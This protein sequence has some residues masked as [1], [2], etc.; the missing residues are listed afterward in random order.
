MTKREAK[1]LAKA[2]FRS[3]FNKEQFF[4]FISNLFKDYEPLAANVVGGGQLKEAFKPF[5]S[6]YER[7]GKYTD[8]ED[9]VI[10]TIIVHLQKG[11]SLERARTAQR[12][13]V[14]AYLKTREKDAALVAFVSPDSSDWRL[15]LVKFETTFQ[16]DEEKGKLKMV[17]ETT[18]AKR[19]SFLIGKNEG[20]HTVTSR[21]LDLLQ[22]DDS[23]N[24]AE[25]EA[26]FDVETVSKEFYEKYKELFLR[27]KEELDELVKK[28]ANIRADFEEKD[29]STV[30]FAKK[31]MGQMVFLYFLQK[32]GWFGVKPKET[33]G[34]G[35]KDFLRDLFNRR[36]D[37]NFFDDIMEPLFYEALASDRRDSK[38]FYSKLN[39]R[40]P[41][42][43]GGLFEPIQGYAWKS[44]H[45]RLPDK[46]FSNQ[47]KTKEGDVGDGILDIFDRY[48]FTVNES[49]PLEKEVAVD[50]EML[51][52]VFENL[53]EIKDRKSKGTYYTPREIVHYM[54]QQCLINHLETEL[55]EHSEIAREDIERL[56]L[57][58]SRIIEHEQ[59]VSKKE[60]ET[61]T[62]S[63]EMPKSIRS[64]ANRVDGLLASIKVCDPAVGSG[65]F[66]L[67]ML[68]EIIRARAALAVHKQEEIDYYE[69][70][71]HTIINSLYGVDLDGGA[72]EIAKLRLWLA[73]VVEEDEPQP[74]PNLECKIM[75][76]NSL[77]SQYEGITLFDE[78]ILF[79]DED[80]KSRETEKAE[81]TQSIATL[82]SR[83]FEVHGS[84][85]E[86]AVKQE[87]LKKIEKSIEEQQKRQK[88]LSD[89]SS[90]SPSEMS[91]FASPQERKRVHEKS[92]ELQ[93]LIKKFIVTSH[94]KKSLKEKI[95]NL[96]W[97]LIEATLKARSNEATKQRSNEA[98]KQ[99]SNEATKQRSNEATKQRSNEATK[100]LNEIKALRKKQEQPFFIWQ[101]EFLDV[102]R[103]NSGFDVVIGNPPY[104]QLQTK[105]KISA[106]IQKAYQDEN[107]HTF[108]KT[109]DIYA[110]F[111]E[112]GLNLSKP[113]TGLL[114]LI[115][116][117]KWMRA[118]YGASL[119]QFLSWHQ[120]VEC[121]DFGGYQVFDNATVDTN[122]LTIQHRSSSGQGFSACKIGEDYSRNASLRQYIQSN[123]GKLTPA[124]DEGWCLGSAAEMALKAKIEQLG[125]PLKDWD[126]NINRGILTGFNEAFIIDKEKRDELVAADPKSAEII[127][128]IL[129]GRDVQRY[130]SPWKGKYLIATLPALNLDINDYPAIKRYLQSFGRKLHQTGEVI[131]SS[132]KGTP[133]KSR[134][135][136]SNKWFETQDQIAY[137][138][139]FEKEKLAWM[140]ITNRSRCSLI[141]S[142]MYCEATAFIMTCEQPKAMTA[143]LNSSLINWYFDKICPGLGN[144]AHRW[145]KVYV[146]K[147]PMID[148]QDA[149]VQRLTSKVDAILSQANHEN[150]DPANPPKQQLNL[151]AEIDDLVFDL[152]QLTH[153]E[154][155]LIRRSVQI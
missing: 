137:Y 104:V 36:S 140:E 103:E 30:D 113:E 67:G 88:A 64:E 34:S 73:L 90:L 107:Y 144:T 129:R 154:R 97:E 72:V 71:K 105:E 1:E 153:E 26:A 19:W 139:D 15:S 149:S 114:S 99:R 61:K 86:P 16:H 134:K 29:I 25:L 101:L 77:I 111:Y 148:L 127:K 121:I 94:N 112:L 23:P 42:L 45:I 126:V 74:L 12:N 27:M 91:L 28:D 81:I 6:H 35:R 83:Y 85:L 123:T 38:D 52:K 50:P 87:E 63:F 57:N 54:C 119:R 62:Y 130:S 18:P 117:N 43:N 48:N 124:G 135:A 20:T 115:T 141:P 5:V 133:I 17:S 3:P 11:S 13:F 60:K 145:K 142:G 151:E 146:E 49:E 37:L 138:K 2:T 80:I 56:I 152:Y 155:Q 66:P 125:T 22:S 150:Y 96:K 78:T 95:D 14:A 147:I 59:T 102:F 69:L 109:G 120:G 93:E 110:L 108:E 51:G 136:T 31:T 65:A 41:F 32:K 9:K 46:L 8:A 7:I 122:I 131:G 84:E 39:C 118:K 100:Q 44:T 68:N 75:Q 21:F 4:K 82:Q 24:L 76:G 89:S 143:L 98:T 40:M 70:K 128:P 132:D 116:S 55:R 92:L 106:E 58:S 10:D 53:L 33:W 47:N 79:K